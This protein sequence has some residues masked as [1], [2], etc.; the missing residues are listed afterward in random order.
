MVGESFLQ[1]ILQGGHRSLGQITLS[2]AG[3]NR[4]LDGGTY[5]SIRG[6]E[7]EDRE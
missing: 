6:E 1:P 4:F 3:F 5:Q 7:A 2:F